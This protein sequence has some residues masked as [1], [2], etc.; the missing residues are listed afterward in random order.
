MTLKQNESIEIGEKLASVCFDSFGT[1]HECHKVFCWP[2]CL[3]QA[4][5][6]LMRTTGLASIGK[7][8]QQ[9]CM[10]LDIN[11]APIT[12]RLMQMCRA[13]YVL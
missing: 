8:R 12:L 7:G 9:T 2:L 4:V 13:W 5:L 6:L 3:L 10:T 1:A 11:A